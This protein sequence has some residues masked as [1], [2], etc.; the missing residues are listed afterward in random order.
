MK[1]KLHIYVGS[2]A[3]DP[4]GTYMYLELKATEQIYATLWDTERLTNLSEDRVYSCIEELINRASVWSKKLS[5]IP[6]LSTE[7]IRVMCVELDCDE[8]TINDV[9]KLIADFR[10][11][12]KGETEND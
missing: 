3:D 5:I 12:L 8:S 9:M 4:F 10:A 2:T 6:H 1:A 7:E 11:Q